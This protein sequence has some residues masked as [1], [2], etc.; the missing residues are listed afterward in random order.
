MSS[1][2]GKRSLP[3]EG[4]T[5]FPSNDDYFAEFECG[6]ELLT[7]ADVDTE[8]FEMFGMDA[9]ERLPLTGIEIEFLTD[10]RPVALFN[11]EHSLI[12]VGMDPFVASLVLIKPRF[13]MRLRPIDEFGKPLAGDRRLSGGEH[14]RVTVQRPAGHVSHRHAWPSVRSDR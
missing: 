1:V 2:A 7:P 10:L 9:P 3:F 4:A 12:V 8:P 6:F 13:E 11:E 14:E 5:L